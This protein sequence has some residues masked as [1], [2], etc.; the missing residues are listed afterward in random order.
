MK[1]QDLNLK[2]HLIMI[3][4]YFK[5]GINNSFWADVI[6]TQ[7]EQR[8]Q[9]RIWY[10]V[11]LSITIEGETKI[12]HDKVE[13]TQYPS[14]NQ[15]PQR[16]IERKFKHMEGNY[17]QEKPRNWSHNKPKGRELHKHNSISNNKNGKNLQSLVLNIYNG[18][19]SP[20]KR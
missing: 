18:L 6:Q 2:S 12:F 9:P 8:Y 20:I 19:N 14:T 7:R 1:K 13:F 16:I 15:A 11:K 5:K 3:I 10:P 17:T 4:E